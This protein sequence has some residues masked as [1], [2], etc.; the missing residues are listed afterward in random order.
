[1]NSIT[2]APPLEKPPA[3]ASSPPCYGLARLHQSYWL[4]E[5][6][7]RKALATIFAGVD[8]PAAVR[9]MH[10][11]GWTRYALHPWLT[12]FDFPVWRLPA[13]PLPCS[14]GCLTELR[15]RDHGFGMKHWQTCYHLRPEMPPFPRVLDAVGIPS[16]VPKVSY[17][18]GIPTGENRWPPST[19]YVCQVPTKPRSFGSLVD[20]LDSL[21][22][23]HPYR[24][25]FQTDADCGMSPQMFGKYGS[26][27]GMVSVLV[28]EELVRWHDV[29]WELNPGTSDDFDKSR[30]G[31]RAVL[32]AK[33]GHAATS[34]T[35]ARK[36]TTRALPGNS[37]ASRATLRAVSRNGD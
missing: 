3:T 24:H 17:D 27:T 9:Y 11:D 34:C 8:P 6:D 12:T 28:G 22:W 5:D 2:A 10:P 26:A 13:V 16:W 33:T 36:N 21:D 29:R 37:R 14:P 1:M 18:A 35:G 19:C 20:Y 23:K 25:I 7:P 31:W 30:R 15:W 32:P 4:R